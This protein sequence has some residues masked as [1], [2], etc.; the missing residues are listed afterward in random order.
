MRF[1]R[2]DLVHIIKDLPD[3]MSHFT[4]DAD[5]I[6]EYSYNERLWRSRRRGRSK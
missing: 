4:S 3:F 5:A 2:G 6:V 1:K